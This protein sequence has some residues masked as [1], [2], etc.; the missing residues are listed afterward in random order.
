MI[1][2]ILKMSPNKSRLDISSASATKKSPGAEAPGLFILQPESQTQFADEGHFL[3]AVTSKES[4]QLKRAVILQYFTPH[5]RG[6]FTQD[7]IKSV[8]RC[9]TYID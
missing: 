3:W 5:P 8:V 7:N 1:S 2:N 6:L 4:Q 9:R